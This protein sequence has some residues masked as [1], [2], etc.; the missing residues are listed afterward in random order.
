MNIIYIHSIS[1]SLVG[2]KAEETTIKVTETKAN[3]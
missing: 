3:N 2:S 1:I